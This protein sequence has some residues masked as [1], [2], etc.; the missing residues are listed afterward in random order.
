M[1]PGPRSG[2]PRVTSRGAY[3]HPC[4]RYG[5]HSSPFHSQ[6]SLFCLCVGGMTS[7]RDQTERTK[8]TK[9]S[10][11]VYMIDLKPRCFVPFVLPSRLLDHNHRHPGLTPM[12]SPTSHPCFRRLF[13]RFF[14]VHSNCALFGWCTLE[15]CSLCFRV[16]GQPPTG[17]NN[18]Q[19]SRRSEGR[20][21]EPRGGLWSP[22]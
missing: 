12:D 4:P 2:G 10:R 8:P 19:R 15:F 13:I 17:N 20:D 18:R 16:F 11:V 5:R 6:N 22:V 1:C 14:S 21:P 3:R 7:V 9:K